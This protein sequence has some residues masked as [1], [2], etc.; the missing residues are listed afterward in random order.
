M[1]SLRVEGFSC[2][3]DVLFGGL[4]IRKQQVLIKKIIFSAV[5]IFKIL[6]I[7]KIWI[8]IHLLARFGSVLKLKRIR[9]TYFENLNSY[10]LLLQGTRVTGHLLD[11]RLHRANAA[12]R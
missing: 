3:L 8:R 12:D 1:L 5:I 10:C 11:F 9:N 2:S 4:G 7:K 6:V